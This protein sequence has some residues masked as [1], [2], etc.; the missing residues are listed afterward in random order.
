MAAHRGL[1]VRFKVSLTSRPDLSA[2]FL[3]YQPASCFRSRSSPIF[4]TE[5]ETAK[6]TTARLDA[7]MRADEHVIPSRPEATRT[8]EKLSSNARAKQT[9]DRCKFLTSSCFSLN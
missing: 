1:L 4:A 6:L 9:V 5:V 8:D 2:E 7:G 3:V